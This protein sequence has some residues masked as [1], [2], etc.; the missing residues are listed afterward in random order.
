MTD[1][2]KQENDKKKTKTKMSSIFA[3]VKCHG[4]KLSQLEIFKVMNVVFG[5]TIF[6]N[7]LLQKSIRKIIL[8]L[9]GS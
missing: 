6:I 9:Y 1:T 8:C 2:Y 7:F 4:Q 5:N 3:G